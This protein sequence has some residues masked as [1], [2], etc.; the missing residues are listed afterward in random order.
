M[1]NPMDMPVSV[2]LQHTLEARNMGAE[3]VEFEPYWYFYTNGQPNQNL[4][5]LQTLL[6]S[7]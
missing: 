7:F 3:L 2:L 6:S 4:K 1:K 5:Q